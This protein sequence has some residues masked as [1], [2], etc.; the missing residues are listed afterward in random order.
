[1]QLTACFSI[2]GLKGLACMTFPKK[3]YYTIFAL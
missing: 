2:K 1:M 3:I